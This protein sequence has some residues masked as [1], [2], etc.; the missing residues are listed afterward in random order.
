M[1]EPQARFGIILCASLECNIATMIVINNLPIAVYICIICILIPSVYAVDDG[2]TEIVDNVI[3][4]VV[5]AACTA[6]D[7][8]SESYL[9]YPDCQRPTTKRTRRTVNTIFR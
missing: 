1:A 6:I 7:A 3:I 9:S 8:A 4:A 2:Y 5:I